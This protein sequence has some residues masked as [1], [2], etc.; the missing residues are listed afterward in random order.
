MRWVLLT[1]LFVTGCVTTPDPIVEKDCK[2]FKEWIAQT[3]AMNP[4]IEIKTREINGGEAETN[5]LSHYNSVPPVSDYT[6]DETIVRA[7]YNSGSYAAVISIEYNGCLVS[8]Q[9]MSLEFI[10]SLLSNPYQEPGQDT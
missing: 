1:T 8:L 9:Q 4:E 7:T 6:T 2:T 5:L 3:K 10:K